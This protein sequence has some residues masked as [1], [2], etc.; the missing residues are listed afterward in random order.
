MAAKKAKKVVAKK[1]PAKVAQPKPMSTGRTLVLIGALCAILGS[2][3]WTGFLPLIGGILV[4][5]GE[6]YKKK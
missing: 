6:F 1:E 4:L 5:L 2:F 3:L